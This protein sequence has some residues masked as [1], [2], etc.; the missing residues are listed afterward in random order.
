MKISVLL[1]LLN[2]IFSIDYDLQSL[3]EIGLEKNPQIKLAKE[4][5]KRSLANSIE[6]KSSAL[7]KI[8]FI[9]SGTKNFNIAGQPIEFPIPFG[10]LDP[11]TGE[12]IHTEWNPGLQQ[13]DVILQEMMFS[14]GKDYSGVYGF[15]INQ[16]LFDGRVF[17]AIKASNVYNNLTS[18]SYKVNVEDVIEKIKVSYYTVLLTK[19]V[20]NVFIKSLDRAQENYNN[21]RLLYQSGRVNELELIRSESAVKDQETFLL[22]AEK[23]EIL[24]FERLVLTVGLESSNPI[25]IVGNFSNDLKEILTLEDLSLE[26]VKN[27]PLLKQMNANYNL[28]SVNINS[29]LSEFLPSVGVSGTFH[30]MQSNDKDQFTADNFQKNS[31]VSLNV[32]LPIFDG[33][34]SSARVMRARADAKK[35]QYQAEDIKNNLLLELKSIYLTLIETNKKI[36]A[37]K[38]KIEL[39]EKGYEI[40]IELYGNGMTTQLDLFESEIRLNQ[41]ELNLIQGKFEYQVAIAK[42]SRATGENT[43]GN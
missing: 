14:M 39:A 38:K 40:A 42:L 4:D 11:T 16:T 12:P 1:I 27:Q 41:A 26:L 10:V 30:N 34:G 23:N 35:A 20:T 15:N 8:K 43:K 33:F 6:A 22:N 7:P 37:G 28:L 3:I 21:T 5:K 18:E 17:T 2:F 29:Y 24:A 25:N 13:T 19:K 32:E 31:S 9:T 36:N